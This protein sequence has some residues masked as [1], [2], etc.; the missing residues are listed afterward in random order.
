MTPE[1]SGNKTFSCGSE[2]AREEGVS[3]DINVA[4][5]PPSRAGSLPQ[6]IAS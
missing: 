6:V 2:P 5:I 4:E 1:S 3:V